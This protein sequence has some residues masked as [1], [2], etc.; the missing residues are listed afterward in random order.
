ME[1]D[2]RDE[3]EGY[4]DVLESLQSESFEDYLSGKA[5]EWTSTSNNA[6]DI[7]RELKVVKLNDEDVRAVEAGSSGETSASE[8]G[9]TLSIDASP[10][11]QGVANEF[12]TKLV[13]HTHPIVGSY[14]TEVQ[15]PIIYDEEMRNVYFE[16]IKVIVEEMTAEQAIE[17]R[18]KLERAVQLI[19]MQIQGISVGLEE[20]LKA[21]TWKDREALLELDRKHRASVNRKA[22]A[23][24]EKAKAAGKTSIA[25]ASKGKTKAMKSIDTFKSL[26]MDAAAI[27]IQL[28]TLGLLD[29]GARAYLKKVFA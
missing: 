19:R 4:E 20:L 25:S 17:R 24:G 6:Q 2:D 28:S 27:E 1:H 8:V 29:D 18:H 11:V 22:T 14:V 23:K 7:I 26:M 5:K 21:R 12:T 10:N 13:L 9:E 3:V 16:S 15:E